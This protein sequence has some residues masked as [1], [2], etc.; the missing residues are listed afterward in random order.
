[1]AT[2]AGSNSRFATYKQ[3]FP[4][5]LNEHSN[6]VCRGLHYVGTAIGLSA[7]VAFFVTFNP[8][9]L[10]AMPLAGYGCAWIGHFFFERN[11]PATFTYPFWSYVGDH[12]MFFLALT[13]RL[14]ERLEEAQRQFAPI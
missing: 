14:K 13:G 8:W 4:Y 3:F 5:Y 10:L 11:K 6:K 12:H 2:Q 1:M 9:F 7:L